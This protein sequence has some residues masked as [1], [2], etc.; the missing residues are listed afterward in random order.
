MTASATRTTGWHQAVCATRLLPPGAGRTAPSQTGTS[1]R[2]TAQAR[3]AAPTPIQPSF[4]RSRPN[5]YI[6]G[7]EQSLSEESLLPLEK[8]DGVLWGDGKRYRVVGRW[9]SYD[10]RGRFDLGLHVFLVPVEEYSADDLLFHLAPDYFR[11]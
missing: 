5:F 7:E 9:F 2:A 4:T 11:S 3:P 1:G 8:G 6:G 10:H